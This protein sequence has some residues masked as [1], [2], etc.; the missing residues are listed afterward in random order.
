[1]RSARRDFGL[2]LVDNGWVRQSAQ[3][4]KLVALAHDLAHDTAHDLHSESVPHQKCTQYK[5]VPRLGQV[6]DDVDLLGRRER[7]DYSAHLKGQFL[8]QRRLVGSVLVEFAGGTRVRL[9]ERDEIVD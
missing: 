8:G 4:T 7:A 1:M 9:R 2:E 6:V 3:V 5:D